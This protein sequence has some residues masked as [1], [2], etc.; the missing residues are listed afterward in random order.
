MEGALDTETHR[1]LVMAAILS[2]GAFDSFGRLTTTCPTTIYVQLTAISLVCLALHF[3]CV[4]FLLRRLISAAAGCLL[5]EK[6][7]FLSTT[8]LDGIWASFSG[9]KV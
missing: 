7:I 6:L 2:M 4:A 1:L 5:K 9:V 8:L 3:L